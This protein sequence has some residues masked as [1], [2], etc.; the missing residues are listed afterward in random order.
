MWP[1]AFWEKVYEPL[2]RRAAGLGRA[3]RNADPDH[4]EKANALLRRAGDR[5]RPGR[6]AAALAAARAGAR[7]ILAEE[8]FRLG[9][10]LL[11]ERYEIDGGP[12]PMGRGGGGRAGKPA[13][14]AASCARTTVFGVYDGGTYG[15]VERVNDHVPV[16]PAHEPRQRLW[17]IV[18]KRAV[19]AAGRDRAADGVRRQRPARHHAGRRG[20][21]L[22]Q[23]LRRGAGHAGRWSSP[24]TT[25]ACAQPPIWRH[26]GVQVAAVDRSARDGLGSALSGRR[27]AGARYLAGAAIERVRGGSAVTG[28]RRQ[29][30]GRQDRARSIATCVAVSGGWNPSVH[31]ATHLGGKPRMERAPVAAFVP[32]ALPPGM[33]VGRRGTGLFD[34]AACLAEGDAAG[35][36]AATK[37]A[38]LPQ[39]APLRAAADDERGGTARSGTSRAA[40][41]RPSSISRTTSRSRT[42]S[43]PRARASASVEHLKRYTTLGMAT[44]Q[45]KTAQRQRPGDAGR[46]H[47]APSRRGRHHHLPSAL[48]AGRHRRLRRPPS[49]RGFPAGAA[50][51]VAWLGRGAGRGIRRG[52]AVAARAVLS[53]AAARRAGSER[54]PR[55]ARRCATRSGSATSRRSARSTCRA[56]TPATFLDR[57][58]TNTFSTLRGRQGALRADAARGRLRAW[59]TAPPRGSAEDHYLHDHH[60]GQCRPR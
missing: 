40:A 17:R 8:D 36:A 26:A 9:G 52:R 25:M 43:S 51:A 22:C 57:V 23:P 38:S 14:R 31:L 12:A 39:P 21:Q 1:A 19:L 42:W 30:C 10:R 5:R 44:D 35:A 3:A 58:Y 24:T 47:R 50:D 53:E 49:R 29:R 2:I 48:H 28:G 16:P 15:A 18:A 37:P 33:S 54:Q 34:L 6:A 27:T 11:A 7:V 32:G 60:D 59:T 56:R 46:G 41:A 45:G 13:R 55:G 4:Y 20:A